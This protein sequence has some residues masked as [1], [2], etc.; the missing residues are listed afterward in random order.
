MTSWRTDPSRALTG[1]PSRHTPTTARTRSPLLSGRYSR[2]S[3]SVVKAVP[4]ASDAAGLANVAVG[5]P[6]SALVK[7]VL[8]ARPG[9]DGTQVVRGDDH[10]VRPTDLDP[11]D[12]IGR[13]QVVER[14]LDGRGQRVG[15]GV[16]L[17]VLG[18]QLLR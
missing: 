17:E 13:E 9:S 5:V 3:E 16:R 18:A 7:S 10:P 8:G 1:S 12:A 6:F 2:R 15:R 14:S 11:G 4:S